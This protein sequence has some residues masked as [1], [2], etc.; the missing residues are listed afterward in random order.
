MGCCVLTDDNFIIQSFTANSINIL[1]MNYNNINSKCDIVTYIK[2]FNDEY[3]TDIN[4]ANLFNS[5]Q[6]FTNERSSMTDSSFIT[7][8][9]LKKNKISPLAM[10]S[11]K[12]D[13]LN[14]HFS[15]K[16]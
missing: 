7:Q 13:I 15:K 12:T 11:I 2:E 5:T 4:T 8:K 9:K 6:L 10:K 14:K 16:K 3:L 1:K